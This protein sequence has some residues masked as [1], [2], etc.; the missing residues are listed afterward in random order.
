MDGAS[1]MTSYTGSRSLVAGRTNQGRVVRTVR[2]LF[3]AT[4]VYGM[5]GWIYVAICS[6][7]AP[8]TL[9]LPLTH[10]LPWLR[11]DT[12]GVLSFIVS[13]VCFSAYRMTAG[14]KGTSR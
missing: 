1:S 7:A 10:L 12:S 13:F 4:A 3:L 5:V 2:E 11:E 8:A 9:P 14:R 6:L